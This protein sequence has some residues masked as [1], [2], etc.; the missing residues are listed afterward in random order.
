MEWETFEE[1]MCCLYKKICESDHK[2]DIIIGIVRGGL[3]PA[4]YLST[5]LDVKNM[6]AIEVAKDGEGR[7]VVAAPTYDIKGLEIL[8]VEDVL[9]SG[10]SLDVGEKYLVSKGAT[11]KTACLYTMPESEIEPDYS[12]KEIEYVVT[13]PWEIVSCQD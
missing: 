8:L 7:R 13:F 5:L 9:E 12:L 4:R 1:E 2:P 10:K 11:V 6:S 3:I